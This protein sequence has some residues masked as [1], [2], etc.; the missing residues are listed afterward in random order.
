MQKEKHA[1]TV[2]TGPWCNAKLVKTP[3]SKRN[4]N[5]FIVALLAVPFRMHV[6]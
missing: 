1:E 6:D 4:Q 3:K 5:D 2:L